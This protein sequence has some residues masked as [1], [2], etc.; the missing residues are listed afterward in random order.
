MLV[1]G[2][3]NEDVVLEVDRFPQPGET[4]SARRVTRNP[5]GKGANQADAAA[6]AGA[7]VR[8]VGCVGADG[9]GSRMLESLRDAGVDVSSV[10]TLRD[11]AT[12]SAYITLT[13]EG[14]NTIVL[15]PGANAR[16][17]PDDVA[18]GGAAVMLAQ[19]EVPI[20]TVTRAVELAVAQGTRAVVT[21]APARE[22]PPALLRGLDPLLV[23]EH[24]A[25]F[26]LDCPVRE[27]GDAARAL[28][29]LG[30]RSVVV[31]L[32]ERGA[33]YASADGASAHAPAEPVEQVIDTT[34]AGDAFA[35]ALAA[36]LARGEELPGAV[37]A[38][39][40]AGAAAVQRAGAR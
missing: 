24:E 33:V 17:A 28:L 23:N 15:E 36:A 29:E 9:A 38:G 34:G 2:S 13:P 7:S 32:G 21:L 18:I 22:V 30:P 3:I 4:L 6:R 26:L 1:V 27:P 37:R 25:A 11:A 16:L 19:L 12:G 31:T 35:G 10:A 8:M 20:E 14:E 5:G 39:L 40:V